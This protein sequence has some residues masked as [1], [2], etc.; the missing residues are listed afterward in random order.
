MESN[1]K[2]SA[3]KIILSYVRTFVTLL[4][5]L[6]AVGCTKVNVIATNDICQKSVEVHLVGVN[7]FEK[8]QWEAV[9]MAD[10]WK[11]GNKLRESAKGYTYVIRFGKG[12][13][14]Y[15][16]SEKDPIWRDVWKARKAAYLFILADLPGIFPD[17]AGNA[18]ARRLSLPLPPR[19]WGMT[20]EIN[21]SIEPSNIVPLTLPESD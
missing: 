15:T 20:K 9:S 17:L 5:V 1:C 7:R 3:M 6:P 13:C 4:I 14:K 11:P 2:E 8:D 18:D 21:I 16:L 12:P 19:G 10:Y